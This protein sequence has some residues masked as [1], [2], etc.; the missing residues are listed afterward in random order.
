MSYDPDQRITRKHA[1]VLARTTEKTLLRDE[2]ERGLQREDDPVTK[3][4]TYRQG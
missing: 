4:A 2:R 3:Q 1:A